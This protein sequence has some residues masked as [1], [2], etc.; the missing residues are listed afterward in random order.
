[1]STGKAT[2]NR[3]MV[4]IG[5]PLLSRKTIEVYREAELRVAGLP[6]AWDG[7]GMKYET[8]RKGMHGLSF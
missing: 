3:A 5:V 6:G 4:E 2:P 1:M 8:E 7:C